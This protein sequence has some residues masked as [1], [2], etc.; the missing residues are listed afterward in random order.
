MTATSPVRRKRV[1]MTADPNGTLLN[2]YLRIVF[3]EPAF[4]AGATV[5]AVPALGALATAPNLHVQWPE[6]LLH[7]P[8]ARR[9]RLAA[10]ALYWGLVR[11]LDRVRRRG[12]RVIWTAHN[13][14]PHEFPTRHAEAAFA[15]W[16]PEITGR[17]DTLVAMSPATAAE[18]SRVHP[19]LAT[20]VAEIPH[21]HYRGWFRPGD[22]AALR[23]RH[24]IPGSVHLTVAA[25]LIR[26]YK[27]IPA[28]IASFAEAARPDEM[29]LVAGPCPDPAQ[30]A[31]IEAL[32][33]TVPQVRL[34]L[35]ALD[36][37][38]FATTVAAGDLFV[39]NFQAILNSGSV[40]AAL[41]LD[42][43]VL[44]PRLG[45]L[46]DLAAQVGPGWLSLFDGPLTPDI[47]RTALDAI[48]A[49]PPSGRPDLAANEPA[50]VARA[51]LEL[52]R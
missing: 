42:R 38:T 22:P 9:S 30:R 36:D 44:A 10:D 20:T 14:H 37:T 8:L 4:R 11:T 48:R 29:L 17:I 19:S 51:H 13:L 12:G 35:G 40:I 39:A 2:P 7:H 16:S 41:S 23:V 34:A 47:L 43:P 28:L 6:Y 45:A 52:Y 27:R 49:T 21:P 33:R 26:P 18:V 25:G 5:R 15:R 3:G 46:A 32:A 50:A 1:L 24:G 31:A